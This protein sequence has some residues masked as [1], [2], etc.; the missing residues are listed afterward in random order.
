MPPITESGAPIDV[1]LVDDSPHY[2]RLIQETFRDVN[3]QVRLHVATDG[4]EALDFLRHQG[5]ANLSVP[6]P[7][8]ILLDL[9]IPKMNGCQF[10]AE[11]KQDDDLKTI[12]IVVLTASEMPKDIATSFRLHANAYLKKPLRLEQLDA[13]IK[14]INDFWFAQSTLPQKPAP[15][16]T[17]KSQG[18]IAGY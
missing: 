11:I 10:L 3:A 6:R 12:P 5:K 8:L 7:D 16:W 14:S 18:A 15:V 2:V 17:A 1:L 9:S 4:L 13:L